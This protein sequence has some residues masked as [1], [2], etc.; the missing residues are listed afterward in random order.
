MKTKIARWG[1]SLA[2]RLPKHAL[3]D[4]ELKEGA[5]V[6]LSAKDGKLVLTPRH[7]ADPELDK[8]IAAITPKNRYPETDWGSPR[9]REVW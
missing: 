4:L 7:A 6:E 2:V 5:L 1:N 8:L 9:G 3:K